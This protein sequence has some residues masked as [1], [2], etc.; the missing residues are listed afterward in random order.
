[1]LAVSGCSSYDA[2]TGYAS[3]SWPDSSRRSSNTSSAVQASEATRAP[4]SDR[5]SG[6]F[7]LAYPTGDRN[8]STLLVEQIGPEEVRVGH[9]YNYQLRVTNLTNAPVRDIHLKSSRP[10]GM[11]ITRVGSGQNADNTSDA[12]QGFAIG[13]LGPKESRAIDI[14][15]VPSRVG[16]LDACYA[17]TYQPPALCTMVK[18]VNPTLSVVAEGPSESDVCQDIVYHFRVTNSGTGTA[19]DVVLQ[20]SL[21]E[22]LGTTDGRNAI[23][24]NLGDIPQGQSR[25]VTAHLHAARGGNFTTNAVVKSQEDSANSPAIATAVREPKLTIAVKGPEQDYV[26]SKVTYQV[27]VTNTG[28]APARNA[29]LALRSSEAGRV[30]AVNSVDAPEARVAAGRTSPNGESLGSIDPGQSRT[31][32]VIAEGNQG[33]NLTIVADASAACAQRV[34]GQA[35]T[36]IVTIP[37]LLLEAVDE[38]DPIRVGNEVVY[39]VK[40]TNQGSGP[41]QNIRVTAE[42]PDGE[43]FVRADGATQVTAN[44]KTLSFAPVDTLAA[45]QSVTWKVIVRAVRPGD[46]RFKVTATSNSLS[47]PAEKAEPTKLY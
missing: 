19:R 2:P 45:K 4:R 22:G 27:T 9:D 42:V 38:A 8:T 29:T 33:G 25:D 11:K 18:V 16:D 3:T 41:D 13:T 14:T 10:E 43:E 37:A 36:R 31:M 6:R 28:D 7:A 24:A 17:V 46:V 26:G 5:Q 20:A 44:G 35:S 47:S 30:L 21:P 32:N 1:M 34:E 12:Q 15:A 40:V 39:D 23:S